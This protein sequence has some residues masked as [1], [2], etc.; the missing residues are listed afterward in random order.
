MASGDDHHSVE[1]SLD[2]ERR[3]RSIAI[4]HGGNVPEF[5]YEVV[6]PRLS[7]GLDGHFASSASGK[8]PRPRPAR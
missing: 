3:V 4:D 5:K 7:K 8:S 1:P 2:R 6:R